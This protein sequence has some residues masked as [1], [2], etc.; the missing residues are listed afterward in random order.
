[1]VGARLVLRPGGAR[2]NPRALFHAFDA[3]TMEPYRIPKRRTKENVEYRVPRFY[4]GGLSK[5]FAFVGAR[6]VPLDLAVHGRD[7]HGGALKVISRLNG[8]GLHPPTVVVAARIHRNHRLGWR[9]QQY[10]AQYRYRPPVKYF[11]GA[12]F[13][14]SFW[15][16]AQVLVT[17]DVW[18]RSLKNAVEEFK[19]IRAKLLTKPRKLWPL[20]VSRTSKPPSHPPSEPEEIFPEAAE[21]DYMAPTDRMEAAKPAR[22]RR[23]PLTMTLRPGTRYPIRSLRPNYK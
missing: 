21:M 2:G 16:K 6:A 15:P 11:E 5:R 4:R 10:A 14:P 13:R 19:R 3:A 9:F 12:P 1:M 7:G 18:T 17:H 22:S 8:A 20:R 23:P